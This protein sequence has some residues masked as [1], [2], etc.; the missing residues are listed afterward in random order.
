VM[1][2]MLCG[3]FCSSF[4]KPLCWT[5][6]G[7]MDTTRLD[8]SVISAIGMHFNCRQQESK[9]GSISLYKINCILDERELE[10]WEEK[11]QDN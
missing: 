11:P 1:K 5:P 7:P 9:L 4:K 10:L 8:L 2:D 3:I 6:S